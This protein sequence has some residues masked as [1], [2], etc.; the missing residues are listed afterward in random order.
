MKLRSVSAVLFAVAVVAGAA[1]AR[2]ERLDCGTNR[3]MEVVTYDWEL[4]GFLSFFAG[5]RFPTEGSGTLATVVRSNATVATELRI[6]SDEGERDLYQYQSEIDP[7]TLGTLVSL[8]GYKFEGRH[9]AT[10]TTFDYAAKTMRR[11]KVD[12]KKGGPPTVRFDPI[13]QG[14]IRDVLSVIY[15]LRK[16]ATKL[17][18]P[19]ET[20]VYSNGKLY[21]VL[22]TPGGVSTVALGGTKVSAKQYTISATDA[23]TKKWPGDVSFWL[24]HDEQ[25]IPARILIRQKGASLDLKARALYS[26]P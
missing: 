22:L 26:C 25:A 15:F 13:P 2:A 21:S 14:E 1:G 23:E 6:A 24:T 5:F 10:T 8:D 18:E 17:Q 3:R 16:R 20:K 11:E 4:N 7:V 9:R 19:M 12:T